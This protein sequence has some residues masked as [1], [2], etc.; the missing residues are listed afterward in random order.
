MNISLAQRLKR[1]RSILDLEIVVM[2]SFL[3]FV[4]EILYL[5]FYLMKMNRI[6]MML[7]FAHIICSNNIKLCFFLNLQFLK[8]ISQ[9]IHK[10]PL[11]NFFAIDFRLR[12]MPSTEFKKKI[13]SYIKNTSV[14][15][16]PKIIFFLRLQL[17]RICN[18]FLKT[19]KMDK[20][21][22]RLYIVF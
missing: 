11:P 19:S 18:K 2:G 4:A 17:S 12:R 9:D 21:V 15:S 7:F 5:N 16:S 10:V 1:I 22:L 20:K 8:K 14:Y 6:T 3:I 13:I